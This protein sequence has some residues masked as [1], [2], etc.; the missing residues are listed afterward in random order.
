MAPR[1][2]KVTK[3]TAPKVNTKDWRN[4]PLERWNVLSFTVYFTEMNAEL[5]GVTYIPMQNWRF[6][7]GALKNAIARYGA[8]LLKAAFDECF[9]TVRPTPTYPI[10]TAGFC[11]NYRI[12][13]I[14]PRLIAEQAA[15][16]RADANEG[17]VNGGMTADE[18][19]AWL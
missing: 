6:E 10:I 5:F 14:L 18:L 16:E 7:Q 19:S 9:R 12:N 17:A 1:T 2:R 8:P 13:S 3:E 11:V 15:K 4:L